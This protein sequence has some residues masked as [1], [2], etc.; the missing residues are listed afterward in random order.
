MTMDELIVALG[1]ADEKKAEAGNVVKKFLDEAYVPKSQYD[2]VEEEKK[3]LQATIS[4]RDKQLVEL[5]KNAGDNED[6]KKQIRDLQDANKAAK[7]EYDEKMKDMRLST[8]I[9]I[10]I[11]AD[12][13]DVGIVSGLFDKSKL[14]LGDDGKVTGLDEQL[15]ALKKDKPFLFKDGKPKGKGYEPNGGGGP[16]DKNP[17]AK[18]TF[19]LTEQGKILRENPEQARA[20]AAAAGVTI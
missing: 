8:A 7:T 4:E 16:L 9:Q 17:F 6:L 2:N 20:L 13:Q 11:A 1:I 19:N 14:I 18:E 5:K 12:A 15:T 10:A 3:T